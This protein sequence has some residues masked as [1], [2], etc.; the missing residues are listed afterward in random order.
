MVSSEKEKRETMKQGIITTFN[1]LGYGLSNFLQNPA[2]IF[3]VVYMSA[4]IFG[5]Y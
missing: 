4:L 3:K 1:L 5:S 2:Y